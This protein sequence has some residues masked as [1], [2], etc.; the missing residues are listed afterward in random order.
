MKTIFFMLESSKY[1]TVNEKCCE[2]QARVR[3]GSARDGPQGER[4]QSLNPCLELTLKLVATFPP[5]PPPPP[6]RLI[7]T[8]FM[9]CRVKER[10][11]GSMEGILDQCELC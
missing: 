5:P 2:V 9:A 10:Y 3:Q 7:S 4:P 8:M 11:V 6:G 1:H